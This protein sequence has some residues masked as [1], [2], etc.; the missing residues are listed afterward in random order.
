MPQLIVTHHAPDLDAIGSVWML[1]R[2]HPQDY[3]DAKLAFTN[4][5]TTLSPEKIQQFGIDPNQ[6]VHVD[7]G[8]GEFDH[9]QPERAQQHVCGT[10]L[11]YDYVC[12]IHPDKKNDEALQIMVEHIT[13]IDHFGEV[14]WPEAA[15]FRYS[16]QLHEILSGLEHL[17]LHDDDS[18]VHFGMTCLDS[19]YQTITN[20]VVALKILDKRAKYLDL[21]IGKVMLV[22]TNNDDV[23]KLGQ[24]QGCVITVRKDKDEH[25]VRIKARP[26]ASFDLQPLAGEILA[27][28]TEADWYYHPGGKMLLNGSRKRNHQPSQLT[29]EQIE[30]LIR[31]I[32]D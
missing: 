30:N 2:H 28:D 20:Q 6:V 26:D 19:V 32:Y 16:F 11:V 1:K 3:A 18:V 13:E 4:P 12:Q 17:E 8:L 7:T 25:N 15:E 22:E 27:L 21:K 31:K 23:L 10:S 14:F 5:G 24:K 9:H 29:L